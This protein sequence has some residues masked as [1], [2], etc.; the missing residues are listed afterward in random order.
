MNISSKAVRKI[1]RILKDRIGETVP[2][3]AIREMVE[4]SIKDFFD[5]K[6][7]QEDFSSMLVDAIDAGEYDHLLEP[8]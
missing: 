7:V 5:Y 2:Q 1:Q 3:K 6:E 8:M 4:G